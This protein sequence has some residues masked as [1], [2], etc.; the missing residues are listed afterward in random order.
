LLC[1]ERVKT[2]VRQRAYEIY[3]MR[4]GQPG[5]ESHDWF[6]AEGEVLAYLIA[7][8]SQLEDERTTGKLEPAATRHDSALITEAPAIAK[9]SARKSPTPKGPKSASAPKTTATQPAKK[10]ASKRTPSRKSDSAAK[11]KHRRK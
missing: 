9:R 5:W 7:L 3:Q 10:P 2:M 4:G 11:A 6:Q 8:E 1:E